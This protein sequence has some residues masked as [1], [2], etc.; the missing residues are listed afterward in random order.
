[1][2]QYQLVIRDYHH[3]HLGIGNVL[4]NL[5]TALSINDDTVIQCYSEYVYG[6]YDMVL[7]PK[8]IYDPHKE[9]TKEQVRVHTCRLLLLYYEE[10]YQADLPNEETVVDTIHPTLFHWYFSYTRRIDWHYDPSLVDER[11]RNRI[12]EAIHKI[13]FLPVIHEAVSA[14]TQLFHG[15]TLGVSIRTWTAAHEGVIPRAYAFEVYRDR[16]A[17][18]MRAHPEIR[19]LVVSVDNPSVIGQYM[20]ELTATYPRC[21]FVVLQKPAELNPIQY[22]VC[23]ALT[24]AKCTHFIGNR[25]ST[26]SELVYWFGECKP[27]VHTVF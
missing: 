16:I 11:V 3:D 2:E 1:M 19:T 27:I 7:D 22:A 4:K 26:F 13:V 6:H 18:V 23:K 10:E 8:F 21:A 12:L 9:T 17:G 25:I 20:T 24:L 15:P 5:I 14:W